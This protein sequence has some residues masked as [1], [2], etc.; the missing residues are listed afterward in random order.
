MRDYHTHRGMS[1]APNPRTRNHSS[2]AGRREAADTLQRRD[3][4]PRITHHALVAQ[5]TEHAPPKRG[6]QV[7]FLPGAHTIE[8]LRASEG[9]VSA[10]TTGSGRPRRRVTPDRRRAGREGCYRAWLLV[11]E[12]TLE[13]P[14]VPS[15]GTSESKRDRVRG[16]RF[17]ALIRQHPWWIVGLALV[18]LSYVLV[19]Q[20][21][22]RPGY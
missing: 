22:T 2:C 12:S 10:C 11:S 7:R 5:W 15:A 14:R 13:A 9:Q 8:R 3:D 17:P 18:V 16:H 19:H 1:R 21:R 6:M 4:C 20:A